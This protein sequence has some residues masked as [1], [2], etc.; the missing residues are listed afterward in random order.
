MNEAIA[1]LP[2]AC[3]KPDGDSASNTAAAQLEPPSIRSNAIPSCVRTLLILKLLMDR[4]DAHTRLTS[5]QI[6]SL[7]ADPDDPT[8]PAINVRRTAIRASIDTLR[9][10]G[11][12]IAANPRTGYALVEHPL[13]NRDAELIVRALSSSRLLSAKQ[14]AHLIECVLRLTTPTQ[15][16]AFRRQLGVDGVDASVCT[17]DEAQ[18][19]RT[20]RLEQPDALVRA[21]LES[22]MPVAFELAQRE[23]YEEQ[24]KGRRREKLR[25]FGRRHRM[26]PT[27]L[28]ES[29]GIA[30]VQGISLD[31]DTDGINIARTIRLDRMANLALLDEDGVLHFAFGAATLTVG[32][33]QRPGKP[34]QTAVV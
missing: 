31:T 7:L 3:T 25:G 5:T 18:V 12:A 13:G 24:G 10:A 17:P 2:P 15:R 26:R 33:A 30:Y 22:E 28:F 16:A 19:W 6:K 14:R 4:T 29:G 21:A 8:V 34:P 1:A 9:T 32:D 20:Y 23:P 27:S 11:I